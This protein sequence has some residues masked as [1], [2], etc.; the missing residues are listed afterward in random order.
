MFTQQSAIRVFNIISIIALVWLGAISTV[1]AMAG[2]LFLYEVGTADVGL[3][4]AGYGARAQDASTVFTNPAGMTRLEGTQFLAGGQ[5]FWANNEFSI[6]SGTSPGLG[7][8]ESGY[9]IGSDGWFPGGGGFLSYSVSPDLKLGLALTGNFGSVVS[10]DDDWVGRYY[11]QDAT[12]LGLSLLPSIAYKV[13]DKLSLGAGLNAMYGIYKNEVAINNVDPAYGDGSLKLD[14]NEWGWGANLGLLYELNP[15]IRFGLTWNSQVDLDFSGSAEFSN[16][17]PGIRTLLNN[18]GLLDANID[19]GITV[20]Q[21]VM[22]SF[23]AQ[24]NDRWAV[25]AS[26]GWQEWSKFGQLQIG[27]DNTSDPTSTTADLDFK[28]TWHGAIGAQ[29]RVSKPWLLNFGIAYDSECQDG[30]DVTPLVPV[31]SAWRFGVGAEHQASETFFWGVATE[32]VYGGTLDTN[33]QSTVP[34]AIGGRGDVVGS[35]DDTGILFVALYG[36]WKF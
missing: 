17:A 3:A 27:V 11:I 7:R 14:D 20:P 24:V 2:G 10:Y 31:N 15:A 28:D 6:G 19:V 25:L 18:R 34:V 35:Y 23:F 5:V 22:G 36:N 1:P 26:A 30:S 32:Y 16:L 12:M 21:Q 29:Y 9:V 4:S 13:T 8:D 33:L